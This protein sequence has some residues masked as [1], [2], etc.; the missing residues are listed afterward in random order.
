MIPLKMLMPIAPG[1]F[2]IVDNESGM[3]EA[4]GFV[5]YRSGRDQ[6]SKT[7]GVLVGLE[8]RTLCGLPIYQDFYVDHRIFV[9][10]EPTQRRRSS[11]PTVQDRQG[12]HTFR[13]GDIVI[14]QKL[15]PGESA[16]QAAVFGCIYKERGSNDDG[17]GDADDG[18]QQGASDEQQARKILILYDCEHRHLFLGTW[19]QWQRARE[20]HA[21]HP[22]LYLCQLSSCVSLNSRTAFCQSAQRWPCRMRRLSTAI[23]MRM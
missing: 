14:Y 7:V 8:D 13:R 4:A 12:L 18:E 23:L 19:P 22:Y 11:G 3:A 16:Y 21:P 9:T 2:G 17:E 10:A 6:R 5:F 15:E 1:E 20:Y